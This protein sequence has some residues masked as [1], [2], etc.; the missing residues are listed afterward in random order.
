MAYQVFA[1]TPATNSDDKCDATGAF[2]P[3]AQ[4][5][6]AAYNGSYKTFNNMAANA[7]KEFLQ[8]IEDG[9]GSL[10]MFAYFGHGYTSQLGSAKIYTDKDINDLAEILKKKLKNDA[11]VVLYACLAGAERGFSSQLQEKLKP[12]IWVYGHTT[13]G[14]SFTNPDVSEVQG[15]RS[16]RYR[17]LFAD[18]ELRG[19]WQEALAYTDMW[20]RFPIMWDEYIIRELNAIRLLGKWKVS[21]NKIYIFEW[22]KQNGKYGQLSDLN[23]KPDGTIRDETGRRSGTWKVDEVVRIFWDTGETENWALPVKPNLQ[24]I[25]G[26]TSTATRLSHTKPG[27]AQG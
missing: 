6:A 5:F 13:V 18:S 16:P 25:L 26:G 1:V 7:K 12:N 27:K 8:T 10:D 15:V 17:K 19:A 24:P 11:T 3:G 2:I 4:K 9:P 23:M 22:N 21:G 14:H 20:L